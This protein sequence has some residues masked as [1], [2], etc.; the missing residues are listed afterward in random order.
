MAVSLFVIPGQ[1]CPSTHL[2]ISGDLPHFPCRHYLRHVGEIGWA[3]GTILS[4]VVSTASGFACTAVR[5]LAAMSGVTL[6]YWC[7][8]PAAHLVSNG[9]FQWP[10]PGETVASQ[11]GGSKLGQTLPIAEEMARMESEIEE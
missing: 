9:G 7:V 8:P 11:G 10:E 6:N 5:H 1:A 2:W 4:V 3:G